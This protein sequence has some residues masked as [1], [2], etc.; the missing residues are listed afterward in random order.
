M[1][2]MLGELRTSHLTPKV[3]YELYTSVLPHLLTF[4]SFL[5]NLAREGTP[6]A[7]LYEG[8]QR[9]AHVLPRLYLM[10][11]AGSVYIRTNQAPAS[12][13]MEDLL[14]HIKAVQ[15]PAR[16]LFLRAFLIQSLK[17][18]LPPLM[19]DASDLPDGIDSITFLIDNLGEMNRLWVRMQQPVGIG[20]GRGRKRRERERQ[21]LRQLVGA[22]LMRL[23][24]LDGLDVNTFG[25]RVLPRLLIEVSACKDR[26]SQ[27]YLLESLLSVFPAEWHL[28]TV[29]I[30]TSTLR[31]LVPDTAL[32]K[33]VFLAIVQRIQDAVQDQTEPVIGGL[34]GQAGLYSSIPLPPI[35]FPP[36]IAAGLPQNIDLFAIL[37]RNILALAEDPDGPFRVT[38]GLTRDDVPM[39]KMLHAGE[40]AATMN[41]CAAV[42]EVL[43]GLV[44]FSSACYNAFLPQICAVLQAAAKM[45]RQ[46]IGLPALLQAESDPSSDYA[47][48]LA[49]T[50]LEHRHL[51]GQYVAGS[52]SQLSVKARSALNELLDA[53]PHA[54]NGQP[55]P[56]VQALLEAN[57]LLVVQ[58]HRALDAKCSQTLTALLNAAQELL[59]FE[60]LKLLSY[61][62]ALSA[63]SYQ[64]RKEVA[65]GFVTSLLSKE[66]RINDYEDCRR[67]FAAL[68]PLIL[69]DPATAPQN[70]GTTAFRSTDL[71][72]STNSAAAAQRNFEQE[73]VAVAKLLLLL[74]SGRTANDETNAANASPDTWDNIRADFRIYQLARNSCAWGTSTRIVYSFP[75]VVQLTISLLKRMETLDPEALR[76][77]NKENS[78]LM[79]EVYSFL[80]DTIAALALAGHSEVALDLF[81]DAA[82]QIKDPGCSEELLGQGTSLFLHCSASLLILVFLLLHIVFPSCP[83]SCFL[84]LSPRSKSHRS[85]VCRCSLRSLRINGPSN[86]PPSSLSVSAVVC[87]RGG[88]SD[89]RL[90]FRRSPPQIRR[91]CSTIAFCI[92]GCSSSAQLLLLVLPHR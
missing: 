51:P 37:L 78:A 82:I 34:A 13:V 7:E 65:F 24:A 38:A 71:A 77:D 44:H 87:S 64:D 56:N 90:S 88:Y 25:E 14:S 42:L 92:P 41:G 40:V 33:G 45:T 58:P 89:P 39:P 9:T 11:A 86:Q 80:Y 57:G 30:L 18:Y 54:T 46:I 83:T 15:H 10:I 59:G 55:V 47:L 48:N 31:A 16:G 60:T 29:D 70:A 74:G 67:L 61:A 66:E 81:V 72:K 1:A 79:K 12:V 35:P 76:S 36:K 26:L 17:D 21:D 53:S 4:S 84:L 22:N 49:Q 6:V 28:A 69:N 20:P 68:A 50:H 8:V 73:Q 3:Y 43:L 32:G 85:F 23:S 19:Q 52:S 91:C 27:G 62:S 63:L 5:S 75:S 2:I